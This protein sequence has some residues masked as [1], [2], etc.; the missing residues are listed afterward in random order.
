M[1]DILSTNSI[2]CVGLNKKYDD[3]TLKDITFALPRGSIMGFIG[4]NG[5]GKTTTIKLILGLICGG[6][7]VKIFGQDLQSDPRG[8]KEKIGIVLDNSFF[9]DYMRPIDVNSVL[10]LMYKTWD[11][12]YFFDLLARFDIPQN[13]LIRELSKGTKTKFQIAAAIAHHPQLL[14][15]DEPTSGLDPIVRS[16]ILDI[17]LDFI[18]DEQN[19]IF[20]SSH[21]TSDLEKIADYITFV[22]KGELI[23]TQE[24]DILA[25]DYGVLR[26][27]E[28]E[29]NSVA[30]ENILATVKNKFSCESLIKNRAEIANKFPNLVIENATLDEIML[31]IV[32]GENK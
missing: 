8:I 3:F 25:E 1:S 6:G 28:S 15:L 7:S 11:E 16:E 18:Q 31:L 10:K 17:F 29:L 21:I 13:K 26:C 24:R 22:H 23:F 12:K 27:T 5:A 2:E 9:S 19:S 20:L 4:E 14:I 32:K 30:S